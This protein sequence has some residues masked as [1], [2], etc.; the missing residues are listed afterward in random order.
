MAITPQTVLRLVKVPLEIDNK[1]QLTFENEQKQREY[2]LSLPHK[3]IQE[4]SYQRKNN[5]IM[6]PE[7]IDNLLEYNYVM[8]LNENYTN[9]WFYAFITNMEYETDHNT[10]ISI[11][12][13]VFQTWQFQ[14]QFK[15]SFIEREMINVEDDVPGANLLP[16][17]LET[18][19]FKVGGTAEFDDLEPINVI[20]YS[21]DKIQILEDTQEINLSQKGYIVNG[22]AQSIVFLLIDNEHFWSLQQAMTIGSQ[23]DYVISCFTVPKLAVK[24]F[25]S[26][27]N[28]IFPFVYALQYKELKNIYNQTKTTKELISTPNN[29]DGYIPK[30]QKLRTYPY[31]YLGFNAINGSS[32]IFR[33]EDFENGTP[34]FDIMSEVNPNPTILFVPKNYRGSNGD[35]L[36]DIVTLNGY[37]TLSSKNDF[38]NSW[39][40]QNSE[41]ISLNMQQEQ[42]N[43]E[44]GAYQTAINSMG[45]II[46][47]ASK[48]DLGALGTGANLGFELAKQDINH[49]FYIKQQMAQIEKQKLLPDKVNM[50]S[51]NSTLIGYG[52]IDKN[53]FTRYTIKKQFAERID[54]FFDMYGY[55]T[56]NVKIPNLNNRPNWNYVKTIGS[57]IIGD[58]PQEDIQ[59]L[60]NMFDNGITLWHNKNTFLDYSQNNR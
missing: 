31:L 16:E 26:D 13:D 39:L 48:G 27:E 5:V 55:L 49:D 14:F 43:Y 18:G 46:S 51:S 53:I 32:K 33:Y 10:I 45:N 52:L 2:F 21:G 38:Y 17:G 6:F 40:A 54:K 24:D 8:Y 36:S 58:I 30:N 35:N 42:Y 11:S 56:N 28:K 23:G 12:T 9:K 19:E 22:I 57:N 4:I 41:I 60:K 3:E 20:A 50:A 37:P 47:Q 59:I 1:N 34:K 25:L 44:I 29:L 7:H 15:E